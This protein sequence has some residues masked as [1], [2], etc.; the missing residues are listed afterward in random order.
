VIVEIAS[1]FNESAPYLLLG[2]AL[3]GVLHIVLE[4]SERFSRLLSERGSRSVILAA[5]LGAPIPLCSCGVLPAGLALRKSGATK[6]ATASF[7]ISVPETDIV[8]IVMTYGLLGPLMAVARP[9]A[10]LIT[11]MITG[12]TMNLADRWIERSDEPSAPEADCEECGSEPAPKWG[13]VRGALHYGFV[14]FFDDIVGSLI[15]GLLVGGVITAL[16][17]RF[18]LGTAS[19]GSLLT[20][21]A[22]LVV[23]MPMYV[24]ATSSTPI[25]AGLVA[26]GLSPGAA[27]VFLLAGPATNMASVVVLGKHLGRAALVVYLASIALVSVAMGLALDA[28]VAEATTP[29]FSVVPLPAA[30]VVSPL[31]LVASILLAALMYLSLRR[32]RAFAHSVEAAGEALGAHL[33]PRGVKIAGVVIAAVVYLGSGFFVVEPGERG[34][35]TRFGRITKSDLLPGLHYHWPFPVGAE[36]IASV[37]QVKRIELG[38]RSQ[39][40]KSALDAT[41]GG[42]DAFDDESWML[43][44][45]ED[46]IDIKWVVQYRVCNSKQSV[47]NYL[48]GINDQERLV[49]DAAESAV[50]AAVAGRNIDTLLTVD[51]AA[52]E[53]KAKDALLQPFLDRCS[54]GVEVIGVK[55]QDVHAPPDVH[56]AFRDV[57]SAAEDK[58]TS[59]NTA[60]EYEERIVREAAG[61]AASRVAAAEAKATDIVERA[62]GEGGA[63]IDELEAYRLNPDITRLRIRFETIDSVY[64]RLTK[65]VSLIPDLE[66]GLEFWMVPEQTGA[67]IPGVAP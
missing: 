16:L 63:F 37:T 62:T 43:T 17:P 36:D 60:Y 61:D 53:A 30:E 6:G 54:T 13:K 12:Q 10:A 49:R 34:V 21:L 33:S 28:V 66:G 26:G 67:P 51:R 5:V 41:T 57:A 1:I 35:A 45:N 65:Y 20:M 29:L 40:N 42:T 47:L 27:L 32:T 50:R 24:C 23:A 39:P 44:G 64:G 31:E 25:A 14:K 8:S 2:F 18:E 3:A 38:Y 22:M 46:I 9:V 48:Y 4:R 7:L 52:V 59:I 15:L 58:E 56:A 19:G 11:A 55:L